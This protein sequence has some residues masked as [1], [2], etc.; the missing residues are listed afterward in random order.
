[1]AFLYISLFADVTKLGSYHISSEECPVF[2][3]KDLSGE[4]YLEIFVWSENPDDITRVS[5]IGAPGIEKFRDALIYT[6]DKFIEWRDI[7]AKN[8]IKQYVKSVNAPFPDVQLVWSSG[9]NRYY[10]DL[11]NL[12][13]GVNFVLVN[14]KPLVGTNPT[15]A[16]YTSDK[17]IK[18]INWAVLFNSEKELN[19]LISLLN[20]KNIRAALRDKGS[21]DELFK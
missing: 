12:F 10:S 13:S 2:A 21:L 6:R 17:K 14:G 11:Q 4:I 8:N 18:T 16:G 9:G 15:T 20:I 3:F 1:M 7:A 5:I 19:E